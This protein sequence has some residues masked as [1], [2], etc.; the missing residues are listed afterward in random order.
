MDFDKLRTLPGITPEEFERIR[1]D[2]LV[3]ASGIEQKTYTV[4]EKIESLIRL[5]QAVERNYE[6]TVSDGWQEG[7]AASK[8]MFDA[9]LQF[10]EWGRG[11][12]IEEIKTLL[13]GANDAQ[14]A[15]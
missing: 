6:S 5:A 12:S 4:E 7:K 1:G 11:K 14:N 10:F 15:D 3:L 13:E 9:Y 8:A 2:I